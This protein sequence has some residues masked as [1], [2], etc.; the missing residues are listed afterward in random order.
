MLLLTDCVAIGT[1]LQVGTPTKRQPAVSVPSRT[2]TADA[3]AFSK[4]LTRQ[5]FRRERA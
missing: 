1:I 2:R 3:N 5:S 4:A